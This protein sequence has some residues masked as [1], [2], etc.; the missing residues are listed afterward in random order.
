M[1]ASVV[2]QFHQSRIVKL[3]FAVLRE[4][5]AQIN[6]FLKVAFEVRNGIHT[7]A[8]KSF[9]ICSKEYGSAF[10]RHCTTLRFTRETN[11][12]FAGVESTNL[13]WRN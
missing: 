6:Y 8:V 10:V 5:Q 4:P 7:S 12:I 9:S 13:L 11:G 3:I 2:Y 1:I